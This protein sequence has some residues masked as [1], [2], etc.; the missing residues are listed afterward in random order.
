[1]VFLC[2]EHE[3]AVIFC[4]KPR[5]YGQKMAYNE[6]PPR[7]K[8]PPFGFLTSYGVPSRGQIKKFLRIR[9]PH[10]EKHPSAKNQ[11]NWKTF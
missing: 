2:A 5:E 1:M 9:V 7:G 3:S 6:V 11:P 10:A 4:P 8:K